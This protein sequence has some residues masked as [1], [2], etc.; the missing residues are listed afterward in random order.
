SGWELLQA[1]YKKGHAAF[2]NYL[3]FMIVTVFHLLHVVGGMIYLGIVAVK[4][5][6]YKI[7]SRDI[8]PIK[9]AAYYWHFLGAVWLIIYMLFC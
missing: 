2:T 6:S 1:S 7:H 3:M 8:N 9:I 4:H 5:F